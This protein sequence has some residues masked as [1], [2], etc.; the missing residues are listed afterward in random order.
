MER[1]VSMSEE[2]TVDRGQRPAVTMTIDKDVMDRL[3]EYAAKVRTPFA[4]GVP[5]SRVVEVAIVE[6]LDRHEHEITNN[7]L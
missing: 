7:Q 5:F 4:N 1:E 3:K 2:R 6:Y